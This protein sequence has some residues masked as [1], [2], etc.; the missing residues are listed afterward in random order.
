[1]DNCCADR[2]A[3]VRIR[4]VLSLI[5]RS[6]VGDAWLTPGVF[7][8]FNY[9]IGCQFSLILKFIL[10]AS[11]WCKPGRHPCSALANSCDIGGKSPKYHLL[12]ASPARAWL[13]NSPNLASSISVYVEEPSGRILI[14][15]M[16]IYP[17]PGIA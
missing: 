9:S 13:I 15:M 8:L 11:S 3:L 14:S 4:Y 17:A 1:M 2:L 10:H 7:P 6:N 16:A 5:V 12:A